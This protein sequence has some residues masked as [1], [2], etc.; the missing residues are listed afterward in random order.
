M[1]IIV[2]AITGDLVARSV[3][4]LMDRCLNWTWTAAP[5]DDETS[6]LQR[7][8]LRAQVIVEEAEGRRITSHAMLRQLARL[9]EH[10]YSG[11]YALDRRR[12]GEAV[13]RRSS[14]LSRSNP[15]KRVRLMVASVGDPLQHVVGSLQTT[16]A[17]AHEFVI[18]LT[19]CPR[20]SRQP[21]SAYMFMDKCMF[22]RQMETE[23]VLAFLLEEESHGSSREP[24]V[25]T[26]LGPQ[27]AGKSTLVEHACNDERVRDHFSQILSFTL[28]DLKD[29]DTVPV[30]LRSGGV[31]KHRRH[32]ID[33]EERVLVNGHC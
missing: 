9:R 33:H 5:T 24:G 3:S 18:L 22:G 27:R 28:G 4:F 21:Y 2:S 14:A 17:D 16:I 1:E 23:R 8:L 6:E 29:D 15:C 13:S 11:C 32:V 20:L 19:G 30:P 25:L 12:E 26:I 7:L 10:M 31:I